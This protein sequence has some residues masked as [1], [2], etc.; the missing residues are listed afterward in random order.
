MSK[1][2][3]FRI[4]KVVGVCLLALVV[5][6][7]GFL[8]WFVTRP[9][10][11]TSG[12][13]SVNGLQATVTVIRDSLGI[14]NIYAENEHDL[15][16]AQGY[17]T[18]QDR[19]FQMEMHR[20][21]GNG[22]LSEVVGS[23][24]LNN[25]MLS[26]TYGLR[27][28]AEESYPDLSD[29]SKLILDAYCAGANA[30]IDTNAN[31][32]PL[33]FTLLGFKPSKWEPLDVL[34]F[35]NF[36]AQINTLNLDYE[37]YYTQLYAKLGEA[38]AGDILP[39]WDYNNPEI[40]TKESEPYS[41]RQYLSA[42]APQR[43]ISRMMKD[44][45]ES[46]KNEWLVKTDLSFLEN[47]VKFFSSAYQFGWASGTWA[48]SGKHTESG[49]AILTCDVHMSVSMPT[50]WY[51][52]GLYGGRFNVSG[53]SLPGAPFILLGRNQD[54]SWGFVNLN[55]DVLDLYAE[56]LDDLENPAKYL[57]K[58]EW[59][60][61]EKRREAIDIKGREPRILELLFT[62]HGP[63]INEG[64]RLDITEAERLH[65]ANS[66]SKWEGTE[67]LAMRWAVH[68]RCYIIEAM[69]L[70]N[71]AGNWEEFRYALSKWDSIGQSF[72]YADNQGNIGYQAAVKAP[73]RTRG[74]LGI[75]PVSGSSGE[76]EWQGY[77]PFEHLPSLYN[78][79][80]GY[81]AAV[82]NKP[83][84][85]D[86]P[87]FLS[88]DWFHPGYRA[89][90]VVTE[91]NK[92]IASGG[93]ITVKDMIT[94]QGDT[95]SYAAAQIN[96]IVKNIIVPDNDLEV[97]ALEYLQSWN[98]RHDL[99]SVGAAI[100]TSWYSYMRRNT[101]LDERT[102]YDL[103]GFVYPVKYIQSLVKIIK[104]PDNK[105]FDNKLT[106]DSVENRDD[107][108]NLSFVQ[109]VQYL[110]DNWGNDPSKWQLRKVQT[111][112]QQHQVF[113]GIPFLGRL[114]QSK[115]VPFA[116]SPVSVAF[117]YSDEEPPERMNIMFGSVQKHIMS[118]DDP[119][120]MLAV[121]SSGQSGHLFHPNRQDQIDK[122]ANVEFFSMPFSKEAVDQGAKHTLILEPAR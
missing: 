38:M 112:T 44:N 103:W 34:S 93:K 116:G 29:D 2:R 12:M 51:E 100:Y 85:D 120:N 5:L 39:P 43:D 27:K 37:L 75:M 91:L 83:T 74:H 53:F 65:G 40:I 97:L 36:L 117:A 7:T 60:D 52:I 107:I 50:F 71:R 106:E 63:I 64:L 68:D 76:Y 33:E 18:A 81:V 110:R 122:W 119:D 45:F 80:A 9:W 4:L 46:G 17:V 35:S 77:I 42:D 118:Y 11:Q 108:V 25:D 69:S 22:T 16:F 31:K 111:S 14:P 105:W 24:G 92:M 15:F 21:I 61:L 62:R 78:P 28:I 99:D 48:V 87:Y 55:A 102:V 41:W 96:E 67:P 19:L 56:T 58:G 94:L 47:H 13:L 73:I 1:K 115:T 10:P 32:L 6:L 86:Y 113:E 104:E 30:F 109:A 82:N 26:R 57:Y 72:V 3:L 90:T 23:A 89:R 88:Y 98:G 70:L 79:P 8:C 84:T 49:K 54:I 66:N 20:R 101:Y 95:Y 121:I 114:Y 59:Y